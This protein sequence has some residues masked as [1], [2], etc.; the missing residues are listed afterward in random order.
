MAR[1]P[2]GLGPYRLLK[3]V[4]GQELV[5]ESNKDYFEGRPYIDHYLYRVIP[6]P[7]TMFLELKTGGIDM[8]GLTP[9]QYTSRRTPS[10]SGTITG[11]TGIPPS[12]TRTW[13]STR[14]IPGSAIRGCVR[15]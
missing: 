8:M 9:I 4:S 1:N 5:L 3:W 15:L 7:A 6:D 14:S 2:V 11:S 13:P 12:S 10:F